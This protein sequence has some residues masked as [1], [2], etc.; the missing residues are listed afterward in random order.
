MTVLT[1]RDDLLVAYAAGLLPEAPS[2]VVAAQAA[3][4]KDVRRAVGDYEAVAG[5]L[6]EDCETREVSPGLRE[7]V[8]SL[9][10]EESPTDEI[11]TPA[12]DSRVPVPLQGFVGNDLEALRWRR[13]IPGVKDTLLPTLGGG[14]A[15]LML[16]KGGV[17]VPAHTHQGLELTLVLEGAFSDASG[18]YG[19]GDLQL[20]DDNVDHSPVAE[21]G[22]PCLCLVVTEAPVRLTGRFGRMLN[23]FV[24]Y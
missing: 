12:G 10:N 20:A 8:L 9:L 21:K 17:K 13:V 6:L 15:R 18:T 16:V 24:R 2:L 7:S 11:R 14:T 23:R 4:R 3:L 19:P 1:E 22:T 5:A